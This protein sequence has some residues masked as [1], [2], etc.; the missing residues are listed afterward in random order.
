MVWSENWLRLLPGPWLSRGEIACILHRGA[1]LVGMENA[2]PFLYLMAVF[3]AFE[4]E[5][6]GRG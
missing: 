3:A 2:F 1:A 6:L 5:V 4:S